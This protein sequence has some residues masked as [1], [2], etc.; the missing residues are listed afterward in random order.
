MFRAT[1]EVLYRGLWGLGQTSL[2]RFVSFPGKKKVLDIS[3][4]MRWELLKVY[5]L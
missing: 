1:V 3:A 2:G 4:S 5:G